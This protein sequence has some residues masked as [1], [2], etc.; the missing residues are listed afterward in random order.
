MM[1]F[2]VMMTLLKTCGI[3]RSVICRFYGAEQTSVKRRISSDLQVY[4]KKI[5][6]F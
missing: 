1:V 6:H 3:S 2:R 5:D 4:Q